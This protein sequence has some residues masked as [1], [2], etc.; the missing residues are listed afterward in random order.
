MDRIER[1]IL[2]EA[3]IARVWTLVTRPGWWIGD[4]DPSVHTFTEKDGHVVVHDPKYGDF[5]IHPAGSDEPRY[6]AYR[7][8]W[9]GASTLVEFFLSE[10]GAGTLLRVVESGFDSL[11][12]SDTERGEAVDGNTK[13]WEAQMAHAK[14]LTE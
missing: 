4:G 11:E 1:E 12:L 9:A 5:P 13:G 3:P 2:I 7:S 6:V 14:R 8:P 10:S